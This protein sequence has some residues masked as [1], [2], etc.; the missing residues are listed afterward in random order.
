ML[1]PTS[2]EL[3]LVILPDGN[4]ERLL[5]VAVYSYGE[6][7]RAVALDGRKLVRV[8]QDDNGTYQDWQIGDGEHA[9]DQRD[10]DTIAMLQLLARLQER[11]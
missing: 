2:A 6:H 4:R 11:K 10:A 1:K 7:K 9:E 3:A 5:P 8:S